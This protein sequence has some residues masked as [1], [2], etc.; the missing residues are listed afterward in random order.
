MS[1]R[2]K[3]IFTAGQPDLDLVIRTSGEQRISNFLLWQIAYAELYFTLCSAD[4]DC[5][6]WQSRLDH[7][8]R[9]R[10]FGGVEGVE[11][12]ENND[13]TDYYR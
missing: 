10:R 4:F 9:R 3:S 12:K 7:Q 8:R 5:A 6:N 1:P 2:W 11:S 13:E